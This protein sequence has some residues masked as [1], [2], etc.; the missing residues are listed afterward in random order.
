[1]STR[2]ATEVPRAGGPITRFTSRAWNRIA[3]LP[4]ALPSTAAC[5]AS[6]QTPDGA[7]WFKLSPAR[8]AGRAELKIRNSFLGGAAHHQP[9]MRGCWLPAPKLLFYL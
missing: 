2:N 9:G 4:G 1:M 7:H 8:T 6:V 3:I 5:S